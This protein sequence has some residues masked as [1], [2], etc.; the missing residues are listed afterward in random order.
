M[1]SDPALAHPPRE[2]I[3]TSNTD[4]DLI[5]SFPYAQGAAIVSLGAIGGHR[6][7]GPF[8]TVRWAR[9]WWGHG[10]AQRV[11]SGA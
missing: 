8:S 11:R 7:Q 3:L 9:G 6:R 1:L 10:I 5:N 4:R 2:A